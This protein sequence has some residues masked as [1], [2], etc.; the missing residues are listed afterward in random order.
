MVRLF[1]GIMLPESLRDQIILLQ[2]KIK[3]LLEGKLVEKENLH[4][5][6]SFLGEVDQN[7]I[8][9]VGAMLDHICSKHEKL[10]VKLGGLKFIPSLEFLRVVAVEVIGFAL[11]KISEDIRDGIG[12]DV[13]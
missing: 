13:N 5:S 6:L 10:Q 1:I 3:Y 4:I 11:K 8:A 7:K 2:N 12:G 9:S